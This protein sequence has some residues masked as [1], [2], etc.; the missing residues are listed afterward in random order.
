MNPSGNTVATTT[1]DANGNY[2]FDN[3]FPGTFIVEEVLQ[4]G[5]DPDPAGQ[6]RTTTSSRP[7]A[8]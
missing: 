4:S 6:S 2:E 3:L 1:S 8:A 7:R 5:L